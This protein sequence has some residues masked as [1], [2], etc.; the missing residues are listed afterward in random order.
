MLAKK[1]FFKKNMA[2]PACVIL[3]SLCFPASSSP[4]DKESKE[5]TT[6][7]TQYARALLLS[8]I[9]IDLIED[10]LDISRSSQ[11]NSTSKKKPQSGK[12]KD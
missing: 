4:S 8:S 3:I 5:S 9:S 1:K 6:S 12:D 2:I 10:G 7:M 11:G